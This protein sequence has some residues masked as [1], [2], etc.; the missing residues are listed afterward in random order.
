M[1]KSTEPDRT[2]LLRRLA[3][4]GSGFA[5]GLIVLGGIVRITGSG[6]GC[7]D[8]WPRCNGQW[9][10][11]LDLP[12]LIESSHR[13]A[14]ALVSL[15]VLA[16]AVVALKR[17]RS[18]PALRNPALLAAVILVAQVLLGAVTVKLVLPP[19]VVITHFA[20]AM[21]LLAAL[22][23]VA[24]RASST[25]GVPLPKAERHASHGMVLATAGL[26]FVV[27]LF[28]AQVANFDAGLLCLGFPLCNGS[29]L[30]RGG[31]LAGLH[32]SHRVLAFGFVALLGVLVA[33]VRRAAG[34]DNG[35]LRLW[36][37]VALGATLLQVAVAAAMILHLLPTGLRALHLLVGTA[38][39]AALVVMTFHSAR[40]PRSAAEEVVSTTDE[41]ARPSVLADMVTLTKPRII[42]LLLVTTVA[43]MFIT[44]AGLP[45]PLLVF[46]VVIGGYLMAGGANAINMW[47]D[48]DID[49]QMSRTK[50]RPI[51]SGRISPTF[52]LAFGIGLALLAFAIF[53]DRVNPLSAWLALGGLLFY[54]FVYT[55]WLKRTSPQNIVIGGAAGAFPPLVGW[56]AMTGGLDLAAVYLF[57]IVFYW[58]PPH[59]WAL[60]LIKQADYAR[61]GIPMMPVAR[62][63][64][65]TK[66]EMLV[67]TLILLPL[68][69]LPS[70]FGALGPFYG[71]AAALLGAR[72][73]WYCIRVLREQPVTP[74]AWGMYRYSLLYLALLFVAMGVDRALPFGRRAPVGQ[75]IILD[76][77]SRE[78]GLSVNRHLDH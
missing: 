32:W 9:F 43:P 16:V 22:L 23:V 14:A 40:T 17:H 33:R 42:S 20:N 18:E 57:A 47:F 27:I 58:T 44:P 77:A 59:F 48:R 34:P 39:W 36:T 52:G 64:A 3:W 74:V 76:H 37:S 2:G 29:A 12:T 28:G 25:A 56:A 75:V 49:T 46:W 1:N 68:T 69:I 38:I 41:P 71:V 67:Y 35:R 70:F 50:S 31:A 30:P 61:A 72:L 65:R 55:I 6:M 10:P 51:P 15:L 54:V 63:E 21:L 60:A 26:G 78:A 4:A 7:G 62:G 8:H 66:Y 53:W 13:W 19:S 5:L 24:L 11:P 45:A 73:L